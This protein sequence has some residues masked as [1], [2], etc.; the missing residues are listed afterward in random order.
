M[1]IPAVPRSLQLRERRCNVRTEASQREAQRM[2]CGESV[3]FR[4][5][6]WEAQE[7]AH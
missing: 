7:Q 3:M 4:Q 5:G 6:S 2:E 1:D